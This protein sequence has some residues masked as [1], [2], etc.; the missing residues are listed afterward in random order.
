MFRG[1]FNAATNAA[2]IIFL[3]IFMLFGE[4]AFQLWF[5]TAVIVG[6]LWIISLVMN[7]WRGATEFVLLERIST[8][9]TRCIDSL[10]IYLIWKGHPIIE[11]VICIP[12][13]FALCVGFVLIYDWRISKGIKM[14]IMEEL[15]SL[16]GKRLKCK[17][18]KRRY[19]KW[20][21]DNLVQWLLRREI[22]LFLIGSVFVLDP[23]FVTLL[24]RRGVQSNLRDFLRITLPSVIH[25]VVSWTIIYYLAIKGIWSY[26][27]TLNGILD[28]LVRI[29]VR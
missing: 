8:L 26:E 27:E 6:F 28:F 19:L 7:N 22:M 13:F 12:I 2:L 23:N 5:I 15:V 1:I 25:C 10:M 9:L 20:A 3:A 18:Y 4:V 24:L 17:N 21:W 16:K 14:P 11:L 29:I